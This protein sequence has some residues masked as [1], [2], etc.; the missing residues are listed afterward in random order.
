MLFHQRAEQAMKKLVIVTHFTMKIIL[1]YL[2]CN[3]KILF[4]KKIVA[5]CGCL[6]TSSILLLPSE[7]RQ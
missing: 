6:A 4:L 7:H 3:K 1:R 5:Y 2:N